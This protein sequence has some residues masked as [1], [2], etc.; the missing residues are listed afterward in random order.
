MERDG[1]TLVGMTGMPEAALARELG[2]PY[3]AIC[4]VVNHAAGRGDSARA[5]LDGRHCAGARDRRWTRSAR[6]ST[7]SSPRDVELGTTMIRDILRM[8]DPRLLERVDARSSASARRELAALLADMR[9]TMRGARRRRTRR[10]ADRRAAARGHLRRRA[11]PALSR[12]RAGAVHRARQSGADAARRRRG[13]GL[14][15]LPVGARLPRRR[16]ALHAA[17]LRGLRP[18]GQARSRARSTASTRASCSTR[19]DHLDGI[20]YP[21]RIRDM[22]KFGFTDVLFPE[23]DG[24]TE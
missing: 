21:Q 13:G 8:G 5:G 12:R 2:L 6:C 15:R 11:Q 1:A 16:A 24:A 3:V 7:T 9:D 17:A 19:C 10:A 4:V 14:G 18:A 22:R 23:L 20:L